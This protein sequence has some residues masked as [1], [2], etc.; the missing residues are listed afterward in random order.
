[1]FF[2]LVKVHFLLSP[3]P[4]IIKLSLLQLSNNSHPCHSHQMQLIFC[5]LLQFV[6]YFHLNLQV[7]GSERG[8]RTEQDN[9]SRC[10][11]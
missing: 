11:G 4:N 9:L 7:R 8:W 5:K 10:S 6:D 3:L 2:Q 1:M